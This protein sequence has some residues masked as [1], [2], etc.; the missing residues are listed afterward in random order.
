MVCYFYGNK[1]IYMSNLDV[2]ASDISGVFIIKLPP[3]LPLTRYSLRREQ[4]MT[5]YLNEFDEN[6]DLSVKIFNTF[7]A[8]YNFAEKCGMQ[9]YAIEYKVNLKDA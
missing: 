2:R 3:A 9:N 6:I 8:A 5:M 1:E 7:L 4:A